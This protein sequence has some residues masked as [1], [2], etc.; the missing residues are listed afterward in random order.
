MKSIFLDT[1]IFLH[2]TSF[3]EIQWLKESQSSECEIVLSPFVIDEL[4]KKKVGTSKVSN[5]ARTALQ[6][7]EKL[8]DT[9]KLE[10]QK[11]VQINI[12]N[13]KPAKG[14]YEQYELN[15]D[16]PDQRILAS[17]IDYRLKNSSTTTILCSD[18][19]GP[20]LRAKT[21]Q[22]ESLKLSDRYRL[23]SEESENEKEIKKLEKEN[24]LLKTKIPKLKL[25]FDGGYDYKKI[26]INKSG[27][28]TKEQFIETGLLTSRD[29]LPYLEILNKKNLNENTLS[30]ISMHFTTLSQ[31]QV[32]QYNN[33]LDKYFDQFERYLESL[34]EFERQQELSYRIEISILNEGTVPG[35]EIDVHLHFPDGFDLMEPH[36]L[37][38]RPK[39]PEPPYRPKHRMDFGNHFMS[40]A[41]FHPRTQ[42][43][44]PSHFDFNRPNIKKTNSY[45][46]NMYRKYVKH[47][48]SVKLDDL[49]MVYSER[50]LIANY[51]IDYEITAA[52]MPQGVQGKLNIIFEK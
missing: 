27:F 24:L 10:I 43:T 8:I 35:E 45:D 32:D 23:T 39:K 41:I 51:Q 42:L 52:N 47:L 37:I 38:K 6:K 13:Q 44:S 21:F 14:L 29:K 33:D 9:N 16:E 19:I 48:Y 4:D 20:R 34:Y 2:F 12:L 25:E 36:N 3:D 26:K 1:N 50:D 22:I 17:I 18:D 15:Y 40:P 11:G 49:V 28:V 31:E 30:A 5:R 46:V 7:I